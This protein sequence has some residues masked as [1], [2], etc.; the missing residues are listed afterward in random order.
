MTGCPSYY[1]DGV[2][3]PRR[4]PLDNV[5]T[6]GTAAVVLAGCLTASYV[7]QGIGALL[8]TEEYAEA[9]RDGRAAIDVLTWVDAVVLLQILLML[10]SYVVTCLWLSRARANALLLSPDVPHRRGRVWVWLGW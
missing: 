6:I 1:P 7:A 9:A 5:S 3:E 2:P 10:A 4:E 8:V